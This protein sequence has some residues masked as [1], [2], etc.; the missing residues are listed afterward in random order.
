MIFRTI[1]KV[2]NSTK[3]IKRYISE[4]VAIADNCDVDFVCINDQL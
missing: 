3:I 1:G 2:H 4:F